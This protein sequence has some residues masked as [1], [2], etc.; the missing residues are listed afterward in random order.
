MSGYYKPCNF[1]IM[2]PSKL[3][4]GYDVGSVSKKWK[5]GIFALYCYQMEKQFIMLFL[6]EDLNYES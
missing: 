2:K 6:I 5:V 1:Q 3:M 4:G